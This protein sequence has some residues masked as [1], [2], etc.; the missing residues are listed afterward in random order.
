MRLLI[1]SF[2]AAAIAS[3]ASFMAADRTLAAPACPAVE[4]GICGSRELMA[5]YREGEARLARL[6]AAADPLTAML[7]RR[8][9]NWLME[10][11]N[12]QDGAQYSPQDDAENH[13]MKAVLEERAAALGKLVPGAVP[14]GVTGAWMNAIG[15]ARIEKHGEKI[16]VEIANAPTY[17]VDLTTQCG[18]KAE[19]K[20]GSDGWYVGTPV[21]TLEEDDQ[22]PATPA[23]EAEHAKARLRLR[24]QANTLRVVIDRDQDVSFCEGPETITGTYF[25]VGPGGGQAGLAATRTVSPSFNC[26]GDRNGNKNADEAEICSDPELAALDADI[27]RAYGDALRRLEPKL[28][29]Q[30]RDDQRAWAKGNAQ[31]FNIFLHPYWDKLKYFVHQTGNVRDAWATRMR[32]R[33]AMLTNLDDKR[34][35]F[36]GHWIGYNAMLS[37]VLDKDGT[38]GSVSIEGGKWITGSH[39]QYCDFD[40][41]GRIVGGRLQA[42]ELPKFR[43]DGATLTLDADDPDPDRHGQVDRPQP[44]YCTRMSSAKARLF[45]VKPAGY[46][47]LAGDRIR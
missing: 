33:L 39:K 15:N 34:Q 27:A 13:R 35:G 44:D 16:T 26:A 19:L 25:L 38:D 3:M 17:A 37:I 4:Q 46:S 10:I 20:L 45:P 23:Q 1:K 24:L 18:L 31:A 40:G 9:Q 42:D 41:A 7:L 43:R 12:G 14:L 47:G 21:R 22:P 8:D 28:A 6:V 5:L 2:A 11:I 32:E 30:L 36:V 29:G